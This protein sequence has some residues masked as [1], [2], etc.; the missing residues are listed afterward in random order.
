MTH[1]VV[2]D[3]TPSVT[4]S[5]SSAK[6]GPRL[7]VLGLTTVS[8]LRAVLWVLWAITLFGSTFVV[9]SKVDDTVSLL[10][11][12][13]LLVSHLGSSIVLVTAAWIGFLGFSRSTA[14]GTV[15]L[16]AFGMTCGAVGDFFN[17]GVLQEIVRLPDPVLGGIAA[18]ALGHLAYIAACVRVWRR[19]GNRSA[20][21]LFGAV[22]VWQLV[23]IVAW[24]FVVYRGTSGAAGGPLVWPSLPYSL[25]L[26]GT[27]GVATGLALADR[28][29]WQ[30]AAG[31][32][33]FLI[34]D[35][36]LAF[37]LFHGIFPLAAH[38]V[39]LTYG[40][41]QMLIVYSIGAAGRAETGR[42]AA[43]VPTP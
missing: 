30:L 5:D 31:A 25:L 17:A 26:A 12:Q 19:S 42:L 37:E 9:L 14:A 40:P 1:S 38:L 15:A 21:R 2:P 13:V 36:I 7:G 41:G 3:V 35:M 18:F 16:F 11:D 10:R 6:T 23:G 8:R 33:L 43:A 39:W 4:G 29:F 22:A 20:G 34:S 24:F 28:R 27:A 32:I